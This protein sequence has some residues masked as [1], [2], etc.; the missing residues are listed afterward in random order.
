VYP[1]DFARTRLAADFG[2][3]SS[4]EFSGLSNCLVKIYQSDGIVGLYRGFN[5]SVIGII[6]YRACYFGFFDTA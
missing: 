3:G 1:L 4:R 5:I 6:V 2:K